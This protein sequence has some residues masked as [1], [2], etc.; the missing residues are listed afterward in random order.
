[1][2]ANLTD[3]DLRGAN[4]TDANLSGAALDGAIYCKTTMPN[5]SI[6]NTNC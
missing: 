2:N 3:A 5:G 6:N 1:M 4:L